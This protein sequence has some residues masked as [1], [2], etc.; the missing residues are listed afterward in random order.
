MSLSHP[1]GLD[2]CIS[3]END[4]MIF[5]YLNTLQIFYMKYYSGFCRYS[6]EVQKDKTARVFTLPSL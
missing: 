6:P 3:L 4:K 5:S 2:V 1:L